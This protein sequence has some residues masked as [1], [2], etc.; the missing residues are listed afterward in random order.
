MKQNRYCIF[1][2]LAAIAL[3]L[4]ACGGMASS[5]PAPDAAAI[6]TAAAA[7][8]EARFTQQALEQLATQVASASL[9]PPTPEQV[10]ATPGA[11]PTG[12]AQSYEF[13]PGCVYATFVADVTIPDGMLVAPGAAF[14]KIWRIMNS[15]SCKWDS[16]FA[17][18]FISGD[19]M[20]E[21]TTFPFTQVVYPGQTVD[22]SVNLVAPT[23]NGTYRSEWRMAVPVGTAGVGQADDNLSV[24]IQV[25]DKTERD[26][27]VTNVVYTAIV[28]EPQKGCSAKGAAYTFYATITVN[29]PGSIVYEWNRNPD[30]GVFEGGKLKFT[31]AGSK[32]VSFTWSFQK[33]AIQN[34]DRWVALSVEAGG[35]TK[36]FDR[37]PFN[38][39]CNE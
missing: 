5:S 25:T 16:R 21:Q 27:A 36:Q 24:E 14:T 17:M 2:L 37:I 19:K 20:G 10:A 28:R 13:K 3:L 15:G 34:V 9:E 39:T 35:K 6:S 8:V 32:Q 31:E 18:V 4:S 1:A 29:G 26:F 33:E 11:E 23:T 12:D 7:T 22:I 30:D 38:F